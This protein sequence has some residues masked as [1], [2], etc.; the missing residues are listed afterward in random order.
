MEN[1]NEKDEKKRKLTAEE[2]ELITGGAPRKTSVHRHYQ[3]LE[4]ITGGALS[5]S[6]M[7]HSV[8]ITNTC[9]VLTSQSLQEETNCPKE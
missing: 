3:E 5:M 4:L 6:E 8:A 2:L 9:T 1:K 7:S